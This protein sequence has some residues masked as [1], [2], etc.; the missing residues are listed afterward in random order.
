MATVIDFMNEQSLSSQLFVLRKFEDSVNIV[1][2]E[3]Y[4]A[5]AAQEND[6]E[7]QCPGAPRKCKL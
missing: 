4:K 6:Y 1:D 5:D 3:G 2:V 7:K